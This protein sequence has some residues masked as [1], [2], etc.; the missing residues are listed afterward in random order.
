M[1]RV[2][3]ATEARV[4]FGE[5]MRDVADGGE[6]VLVERAGIPR[7]VILPI[8]EYERLRAYAGA[9]QPGDWL[10]RADRIRERIQRGLSGRAL[11]PSDEVL[12]EVREERDAQL[13]DALH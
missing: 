13:L 11:P 12:R 8:V 4:H 6:T 10:A 9:E 2:V 7:V 1:Q 3:S 5:L